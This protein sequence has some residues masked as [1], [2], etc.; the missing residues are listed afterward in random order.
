MKKSLGARTLVFPTPVFVVGTYAADGKPNAMVA[1]WAGICCSEPP[2]VAVSLREATYSYHNIV[3]RKAFTISIPSEAHLKEADFLGIYSG[4]NEDKF[5][6]TK[7]TPVKSD[8]VDAPYIK[9]FPFVVECAL[10]KTVKIGLHTQFIGEI[11]DVK[12]EEGAMN[13]EG[14]PDIGKLLPVLFNPANRGYY[15]T[16]KFL[17][18]AFAVGK[19]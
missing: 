6:A 8:L 5:A 13:T 12:I 11:R 9:E 4:R 17:A 16:G 1:A 10:L 2:C 18:T 3:E 7:L 19:K 14:I 15:A